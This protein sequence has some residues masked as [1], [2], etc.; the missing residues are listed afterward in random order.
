MSPDP[1]T[2]IRVLFVEDAF[3]QALLVKAFLSSAGGYEVVHSQ[4]GDQAVRLLHEQEWHI[5]VTDLN[6]PGTDGFEVIRV[7]RAKDAALPILATTG[8]TG[9]EYHEQA[10]RA[11]ANDILTKPLEREE[12]LAHVTGL[13]SDA[14]SAV[15]TGG[16]STDAILAVGGLAGDVEMG[17][18]GTLMEAAD[19][20]CSVVVLPLAKDER[21][22][23][24][25]KA[26]K[27][28]C[29]LLG[30]DLLVDEAALGDTALRVA[31]VKKA[32]AHVRPS[33]LYVPAMDDD[34]PL[35][36]EAFRV[37]KA[38]TASVETVL[39][40]QT[41]TTAMTFKPTHFVDVARQM[42]L[43]MEA[44]A[45]HTTAADRLD[46]APQMAQAYARYWGRY[47]DFTEVEAFEIIKGSV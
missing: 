16:T 43:K 17:C 10:I 37:A 5:V 9:I 20:G 26:S 1:A 44:L 22:A 28:A 31:L 45:F 27:Q 25:L 34:H 40:Y 33:V 42:V 29:D 4:D 47:R 12:F 23:A 21:D 32:V 30:L 8:Y 39:C 46:L 35:R 15:A 2:P 7:A 6:L 13:L 36:M 19:N 38:A 14:P 41:A 18:G 24:G 11:G 3:D